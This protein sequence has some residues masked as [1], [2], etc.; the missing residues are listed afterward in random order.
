MQS[1]AAETRRIGTENN[2]AKKPRKY[3][4]E[5]KKRVDEVCELIQLD[6]YLS[7]P[8]RS[9]DSYFVDTLTEHIGRPL[10]KED[11]R[12]MN[13]R[14]IINFLGFERERRGGSIFVPPNSS[15]HGSNSTLVATGTSGSTNAQIAE[16]D[17]QI[18]PDIGQEL[19]DH[20]GYFQMRI[21]FNLDSFWNFGLEVIFI[22]L[23]LNG[24]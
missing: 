6:Q 8:D 11:L 13:E 9:P 2:N 22:L 16:N 7:L 17:E 3:Y 21:L 10:S 18:A 19:D 14:V 23:F 5:F 1:M 12:L 24:C 4:R 20:G 15:E